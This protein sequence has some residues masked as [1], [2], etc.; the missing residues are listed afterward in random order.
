[1]RGWFSAACSWAFIK[2]KCVFL[3]LCWPLSGATSTHSD[4]CHAVVARCR[5]QRHR[6]QTL[7][8]VV[9]T[10]GCLRWKC[11]LMCAGVQIPDAFCVGHP[12][13]SVQGWL[14]MITI[15]SLINQP[16]NAAQWMSIKKNE[17]FLHLWESRHQSTEI[18]CTL[19]VVCRL[20]A[21]PARYAWWPA[22][23]ILALSACA[24]P[25]VFYYCCWYRVVPYIQ[26]L[27]YRCFLRRTPSLCVSLVLFVSYGVFQILLLV[28][29]GI[30]QIQEP[31]VF[32]FFIIVARI[33]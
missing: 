20:V 24:R 27:K 25:C 8:G 13:C 21:H 19:S 18:S 23:E 16:T 10:H 30:F 33:V 14:E 32:Y 28:S 15:R 26:G 11:A 22:A 2:N 29:Y 6:T 17:W 12:S 31:C 3:V 4:C 7:V 5:P 9:Q 1:M